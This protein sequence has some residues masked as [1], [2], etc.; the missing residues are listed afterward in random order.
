M[1]GWWPDNQ[2]VGVVEGLGAFPSG[3]TLIREGVFY[4]GGGEGVGGASENRGGWCS[5]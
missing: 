2:R 4:R 5:V 3:D 1:L